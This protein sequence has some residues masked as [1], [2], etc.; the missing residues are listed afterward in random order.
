MIDEQVK[1]EVITSL[2]EN[3]DKGSTEEPGQTQQTEQT[4]QAEAPEADIRAEIA[5]LKQQLTNMNRESGQFRR[6][7]GE[8]ATLK[9]QLSSSKP[10]NQSQTD[11]LSK[12]SPEQI[13]ESE[14]LI[15]HLWEK[16]YGTDWKSLQESNSVA[17][18]ERVGNDVEN[19]FRGVLG[20]SYDEVAPLANQIVEAAKAAK[21]NGDPEAA[22]FIDTLTNSP[23]VGGRLLAF[24][25]K[26]AY[27][28][29]AGEKSQQA[30]N[31][32]SAK[33]AKAAGSVP[34]G[35]TGKTQ[36]LDPKNMTIDQLREAAE[37]EN[38]QGKSLLG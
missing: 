7:Q 1:D 32:Q 19:A 11:I 8:I 33:G 38:L 27:A 28:K 34:S 21:Q 4:E 10:N 31:A 2:P 29:Q 36:K 24:Y 35:V 14:A 20:K 26:E 3:A 18:A 15:A 12:Y 37:Q 5:E 23:K 30:V 16:K 17:H 22:E 13:A 6:L 25:A 9:N